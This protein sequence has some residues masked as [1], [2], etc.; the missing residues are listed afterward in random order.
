MI[1]TRRVQ[2][3][4][5]CVRSASSLPLRRRRV[6]RPAICGGS[7]ATRQRTLVTVLDDD[8]QRRLTFRLAPALQPML[9]PMPALVAVVD[10]N[11]LASR[12][13]HA[14]RNGLAGDAVLSGLA[15]TGRSNTFMGA[16]VPGEL[17]RHLGDI[18]ASSNVELSAAARVLVGCIL[19]QV[20][21]V[22]VA[23]GDCMSPRLRSFLR[24]DPGLPR[25]LRGDPDDIET[26][27]VAEFLAPAVILSTDSV[28][29]RLGMSSSTAAEWIGIASNLLRAAGFEANLADA[30][31]VVEL[32]GRLLFAATGA[33][34]RFAT[35]Y[36]LPALAL[37]IAGVYLAKRYGYLDSARA[38]A[39]IRRVGEAVRPALDMI[40]DATVAWSGARNA[41]FVVEPYGP[42]TIEHLAARYLARCGRP[43]TPGDLRDRLKIT[44]HEVTAAGLK[45][46]MT[47]HPAFHRQPG[48]LYRIGRLADGVPELPR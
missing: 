9:P 40:G 37:L 13:C 42:P 30:A 5:P 43:L 31:L 19:P 44:G 41:L 24:N 10:T 15:T 6:R 27:A 12:A 11:V 3:D 14:A 48:N 18:A 33:A 32:V 23:P 8:L 20:P 2:A 29:T 25:A 28:F 1:P 4:L 39:G 45:R 17:R 26:A 38:K 35:S 46:A 7:G 22:D 34:M 47:A 16:H 21:V 36:P